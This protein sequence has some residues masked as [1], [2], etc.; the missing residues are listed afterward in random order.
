[1]RNG[2]ARHL[3]NVRRASGVFVM[4]WR[5]VYR[6]QRFVLLLK[7]LLDSFIIKD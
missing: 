2:H 6:H 5:A 7:S 4:A 3:G 1:M